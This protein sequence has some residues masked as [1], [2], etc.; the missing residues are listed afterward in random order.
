MEEKKLT[1]TKQK[2]HKQT[3]TSQKYRIFIEQL[4]WEFHL[5]PCV[6]FSEYK[7]QAM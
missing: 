7:K 2:K 3:R 6:L 5:G 1:S 4:Q